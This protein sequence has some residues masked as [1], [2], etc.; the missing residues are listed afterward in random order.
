VARFG[1]G[2][3][4]IRQAYNEPAGTMINVAVISGR[5]TRPL[6]AGTKLWVKA[7]FGPAWRALVT[8]SS[9][10]R[11]EI[12]AHSRFAGDL[13]VEDA[14]TILLHERLEAGNIADAVMI[15]MGETGD[16]RQKL[17]GALD[18]SDALGI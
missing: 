6:A 9:P 15:D 12:V 1:A 18:C 3:I 2:S 7:S 14:P 13:F 8:R 10:Q 16:F 4:E 5:P 17:A 11:I